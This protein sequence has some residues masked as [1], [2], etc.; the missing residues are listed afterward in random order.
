ME[1]IYGTVWYALGVVMTFYY[2]GTIMTKIK[3]MTCLKPKKREGGKEYATITLK[4]NGGSVQIS[5]IIQ[6]S[7]G[8]RKKHP[9]GIGQSILSKLHEKGFSC[10]H[11]WTIP[12]RPKYG[13]YREELKI[14]VNQMP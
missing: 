5:I 7:L 8:Y 12:K 13:K 4:D 14:E 3:G 11:Q 6:C 1:T 9:Q 10:T 2:S